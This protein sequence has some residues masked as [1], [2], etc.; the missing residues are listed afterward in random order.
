[1]KVTKRKFWGATL[2]EWALIF[3]IQLSFMVFFIYQI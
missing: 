2:G 1:M 3:L